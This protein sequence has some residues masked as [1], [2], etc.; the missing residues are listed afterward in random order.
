[1]FARFVSV[2]SGELSYLYF[3]FS[4]SGGTITPAFAETVGGFDPFVLFYLCREKL[5]SEVEG[6]TRQFPRIVTRFMDIKLSR[7]AVPIE[8][9]A[10][11]GDLFP[12]IRVLQR[13]PD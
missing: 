11:G 8:N 5:G 12:E 4:E 9:D 7:N 2:V 3:Y 10:D 13:Y 6:L 1:M